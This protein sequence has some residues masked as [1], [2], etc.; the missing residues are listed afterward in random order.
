MQMPTP[1]CNHR[2]HYALRT[3]QSANADHAGFSRFSKP[4][5]SAGGAFTSKNR[6]R[7]PKSTTLEKDA[8]FA[9]VSTIEHKAAE[10]RTMCQC[11]TAAPLLHTVTHI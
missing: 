2:K 1:N 10:S 9:M 3:V 11:L 4:P 7:R 5:A 8:H 6:K